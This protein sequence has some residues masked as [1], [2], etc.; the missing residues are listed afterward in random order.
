MDFRVFFKVFLKKFDFSVDG[1]KNGPDYRSARACPSP[2][3]TV[4]KTARLI[5]VARGPVP[6]DRSIIAARG[7]GHRELSI[8]PGTAGDRPP[9]YGIRSGFFHRSA[10]ACPSRSL[11]GTEN[12]PF[13][14]SARACPS[15]AFDGPDNAPFHRSARA[16]PSRAFD[17]RNARAW[18]SRALDSP[19]H[20]GGQAPA[21][22]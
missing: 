20:G 9:P 3:F 14:R 19:W 16:C 7:P 6:R 13:H 5:T 22:R 11:D 15:R 10:R 12:T 2:S 8:I 21:L 18:S 17:H 4:S 1:I